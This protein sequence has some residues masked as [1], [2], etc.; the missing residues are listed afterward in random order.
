MHL[1][2]ALQDLIEKVMLLKKAVEKE[3]RIYSSPGIS[4]V[5]RKLGEYS[6]LLASQGCINTA[7]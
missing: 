4:N 1:P 3:R 6:G 7:L 2:L 5:S